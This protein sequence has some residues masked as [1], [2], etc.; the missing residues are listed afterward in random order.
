[1]MNQNN[2]MELVEFI[3]ANITSITPPIMVNTN[4]NNSVTDCKV[5]LEASSSTDIP[6]NITPMIPAI[7]HSNPRLPTTINVWNLLNNGKDI[8]K[9]AKSKRKRKRLDTYINSGEKRHKVNE[10]KSVRKTKKACMSTKI[11]HC[12]SI[13]DDF[14]LKH[15]GK[16]PT[17]RHMMKICKCGFITA[18]Q[19]VKQYAEHYNCKQEDIKAI[20]TIRYERKDR[21]IK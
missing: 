4:N 6:L 17:L 11:K 18:H 9:N 3:L 7:I 21:T 2:K 16:L 15:N 8:D 20:M 10:Q 13:L 5:K 19:I 12:I 1:M 14:K